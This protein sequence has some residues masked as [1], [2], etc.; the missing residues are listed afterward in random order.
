MRNLK[1][2]KK[3]KLTIDLQKE[4]SD[5]ELMLIV[6]GTSVNAGGGS[7]SS[8]SGDVCC[9]GTCVCQTFCCGTRP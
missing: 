8:T 6:G 7:S 3:Q 2:I 9:D 4:L 1:N 5:E